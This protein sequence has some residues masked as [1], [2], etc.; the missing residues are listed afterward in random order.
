MKNFYKFINEN[1]KSREYKIDFIKKMLDIL[2]PDDYSPRLNSAYY[3]INKTFKHYYEKIRMNGENVIEEENF[4]IKYINKKPTNAIIVCWDIGDFSEDYE[5]LIDCEYY[6][7]DEVYDFYK[8]MLGDLD[9][10][11]FASAKNMGLL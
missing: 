2:E 4:T 3:N 8:D 6:I 11:D 10:E 7:L 9:I 5:H 1:N